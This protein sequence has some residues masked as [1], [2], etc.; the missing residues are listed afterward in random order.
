M[1]RTLNLRC[2][3][4]KLCGKMSE[5]LFTREEL[6]GVMKCLRED[7]LMGL[8]ALAANVTCSL[9]AKRNLTLNHRIY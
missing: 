3:K 9:N 7:V 2:V 6:C 1:A 8:N 5:K 4:G